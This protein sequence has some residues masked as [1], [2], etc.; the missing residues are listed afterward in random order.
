M[1]LFDKNY[2]TWYHGWRKDKIL[3]EKIKPPCVELA[4][5][6]EKPQA[7]NLLA[8]APEP[9]IKK[10][11]KQ[12]KNV[13]VV[14]VLQRSN[15][16]DPRHNIPAPRYKFLY[17]YPPPKLDNVLQPLENVLPKL[18]K[19]WVTQSSESVGTTRCEDWSS[20]REMMPSRGIPVIRKIPPGW[21]IGS[22]S[23]PDFVFKKIKHFP[24]VASPMS[25]FVDHVHKVD[26]L[27]LVH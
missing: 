23:P 8:P 4:K 12:T 19:K 18:G 3:K 6:R 21:G 22:S 7:E 26:R 17:S 5:K 16:D 9:A 11:E 10:K 20:L 13:E 15:P 27:F 1:A 14:W 24:K 2:T 25:Q